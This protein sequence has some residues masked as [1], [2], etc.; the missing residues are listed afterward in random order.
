M[1]SYI[2]KRVLLAIFTLFIISIITFF[3]M[4]AIPGGP[5]DSEKAT[6][7]EV[8]AALE[9]RYNLDKPLMTQYFIYLNNLFHGDWGIS[10]KTGR[11]IKPTIGSRFA[12]S[13]RL[14]GMALLV[15]II[16]GII[17]G[18]LA[19]LYRNRWPD[20]VIIFF[21][22]LLTAMPSFVLATLLLY[23]FSIQLGW[24]PVWSAD[25]TNYVLPVIS[26]ALYPTAYITRLTKSS[27]LD[28]LGQDYIRT[29]E[30]KG[31]S[32]SKVLFKHALR[33]ALIPVVTYIGPEFAYI[34]TGSLVVENIF[35]IG[36]LGQEFVTSINNRDYSMIMATTLFLAT[37]MVAVNLLTDILYKVIDP[38]IEL[39]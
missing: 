19:A 35:T 29:A 7:P 10:I 31:V 32:R 30:A 4:N 6:T 18:S 27:M 26:L 12:I 33:N 23:V 1:K 21:T 15:S 28:V 5:F 22:T 20:R 8:K 36:G 13:A 34:I 11:E 14:G 2:W 9:E 17:F 3:T 24:F 39:D 38:R 25:G 37:V 16:F